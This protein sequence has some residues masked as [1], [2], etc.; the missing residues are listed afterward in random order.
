MT[1]LNFSQRGRSDCG[2]SYYSIMLN[3]LAS[4]LY[5]LRETAVS[6]P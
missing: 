6:N 2:R 4:A 3:S 1:I 5:R